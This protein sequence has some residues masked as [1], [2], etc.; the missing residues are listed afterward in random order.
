MTLIIFCLVVF[1]F[2]I[3]ICRKNKLRKESIKHIN[4]TLKKFNLKSEDS[5]SKDQ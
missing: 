3:K 4:N 2:I 5:K 1:I